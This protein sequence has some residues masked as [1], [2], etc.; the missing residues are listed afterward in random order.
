MIDI[1]AESWA[2][3]AEGRAFMTR[4]SQAWG[5]AHQESGATLAEAAATADRTTSFYTAG[6]PA[7]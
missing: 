6:P 1:V 7:D 4:S 2:R 5:A 3:P